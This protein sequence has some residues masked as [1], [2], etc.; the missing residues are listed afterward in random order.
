MTPVCPPELRRLYRE[1]RVLPF[2]GAGASMALSWDD[3][4]LTKRAPS[5]NQ[6]VDEAARMLGF[7][8]P[9]LLRMRGNNLQILEY[10]RIK[11]ALWP[12]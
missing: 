11:Q 9:S 2:V 8:E 3:G 12:N 6:L 10:C 7:D 1:R 4:G 5:W